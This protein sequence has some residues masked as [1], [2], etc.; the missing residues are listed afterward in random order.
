MAEDRLE[1]VER[2]LTELIRIVGNTNA[3]VEELREGQARI[4]D[5]LDRIET[6]LARVETELKE[7]KEEQKSIIAIVGE[8]EVAIRTLRRIPV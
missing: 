1:H 2:M 4:E 3:A 7:I 8:H 6:R 5:R